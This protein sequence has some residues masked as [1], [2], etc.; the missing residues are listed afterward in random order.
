MHAALDV[1]MPNYAAVVTTEE[2][3]AAMRPAVGH[4]PQKVRYLPK[5]SGAGS[6]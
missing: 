6:A 1:N 5:S 3:V 2:I 4:V